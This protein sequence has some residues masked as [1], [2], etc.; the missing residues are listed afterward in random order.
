MSENE[1]R[2][3]VLITGATGSLGIALAHAFARQGY[4]LGIHHLSRHERA[5]KLLE[6]TRELGG[7]GILLRGDLTDETRAVEMVDA[8]K[9]A[10]PRIDALV[11]NVGGND[12]RLLHYTEKEHWDKALRLNLDPVYSVTRRVL[13][14]M[15]QERRGAIISISSIAALKGLPGQTAYAA[16]KAGVHGFTRS[17]AREVGRFS[18][19]VNAIAPGA[20]RSPA[21][22]ELPEAKRRFLSDS[23]CLGR[24]G[25]A[26]EVAALAVFLASDEAAFITAQVIAVDGGII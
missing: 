9:A 11:N 21:V 4:F 8:F 14:S 7:D 24:L 18:I 2:P 5:E 1:P 26:S 12:D 3:G 23:A 16:A 20:I 17:L 22:D 6:E 25:E 19:R 15:V 13:P 10:T